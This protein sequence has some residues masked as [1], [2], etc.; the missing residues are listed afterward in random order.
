MTP[1]TPIE[2]LLRAVTRMDRATVAAALLDF[3]GSFPVDFTPA[4]VA[5]TDVDKL[6]HIYFALC[7]QT[8]RAP[9]SEGMAVGPIV[10]AA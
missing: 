1:P 2:D 9:G 6:R 3:R 10:Q 7:L 4:F 8:R 5:A